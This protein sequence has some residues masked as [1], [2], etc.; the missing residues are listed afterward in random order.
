MEDLPEIL[1]PHITSDQLHLLKRYALELQRVNVTHNLISRKD[2]AFVWEHH[3]IPSLLF[4][5]WWRFPGGA[6][7]LDIGTGG[8]LPGIPLA[9]VH[10]QTSFLLIDSTRK[11]VEAVRSIVKE[12]GLS[13]QVEV[14]WGRAE[15][16]SARFPFIVGRAVAPLPR[17]LRWAEKCLLSEGTVYYYTGES[18]DPLP[19]QW[20]GK[21]YSFRKLVPQND[22]IK[23]K[24]IF[25]L[26]LRH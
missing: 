13:A 24:G 19:P 25:R 3:I 20:E 22:Y 5:G 23:G 21:F 12:L 15:L 9:I 4:L 6:V 26:R 17:F 7:V 18:A 16:L 10:P 8:G 11:K 2:I 14:Q 1:H